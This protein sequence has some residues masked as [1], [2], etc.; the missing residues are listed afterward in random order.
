MDILD[1]LGFG[2][3]RCGFYSHNG[4]AHHFGVDICGNRVDLRH[5]VVNF[6]ALFEEGHSQLGAGDIHQPGIQT[7]TRTED[8]EAA[9]EHVIRGKASAD[10]AGLD[11]IDGLRDTP[12]GL[13]GFI[14]ADHGDILI[15]AE[16]GLKHVLDA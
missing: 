2:R 5:Q 13:C 12:Q 7:D 3:C 10:L 4:G 15:L 16:A 8:G 6:L 9:D 11:F 1:R 14:L